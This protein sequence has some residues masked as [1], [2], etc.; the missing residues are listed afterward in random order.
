[1]ASTAPTAAAAKVWPSS[2]VVRAA[3]AALRVAM[4]AGS[5]RGSAIAHTTR[6][7]GSDNGTTGKPTLRYHA[8]MAAT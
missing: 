8:R 7:A 6:G 3:N 1:M 5:V 2:F 4:A